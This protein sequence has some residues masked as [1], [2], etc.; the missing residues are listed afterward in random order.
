MLPCF[1]SACPRRSGEWGVRRGANSPVRFV[2]PLRIFACQRVT[3]MENGSDLTI[4]A[5]PFFCAFFR[6]RS[7][8]NFKTA[9]QTGSLPRFFVCRLIALQVRP[10][11]R[12]LGAIALRSS[13]CGL[14][15][16][17]LAA[18][19]VIWS[20]PPFCLQFVDIQRLVY[21]FQKARF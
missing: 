8:S 6:R 2:C 5:P 19:G 18:F 3:Q 13:P 20:R 14:R 15:M 10:C 17:G 11:G 4:W 16:L 12:S 1:L 9:W 7:P 21:D